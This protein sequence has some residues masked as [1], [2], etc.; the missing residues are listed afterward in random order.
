MNAP[1][2]VLPT[3]P[4]ELAGRWIAWNPAR[5]EIVASGLTIQEV[6]RAAQD[7]GEASP[8]LA[9]VPRSASH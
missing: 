6:L 4:K 7:K 5:T 8:I 3:V 2:K 9:K 1:E